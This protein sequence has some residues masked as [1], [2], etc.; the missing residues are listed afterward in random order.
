[1]AQPTENDLKQRD[2]QST[3]TNTVITRVNG[4]PTK[5]TISTRTIDDEMIYKD[6]A[7]R[8]QDETTTAT[9]NI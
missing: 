6:G 9:N 2:S 8:E 7:W 5:E 4:V 1:M 3:I